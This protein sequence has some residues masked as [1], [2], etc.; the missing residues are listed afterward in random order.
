GQE[1]AQEEVM[2][3]LPPDRRLI[4]P[5]PVRLA[6]GLER[7]DRSGDA[8]GPEREAVDPADR[9]D[10]LGATLVEPDDRRAEGPAGL[11]GDDD[12][13]T[14]RRER[15]AGDLVGPGEATGPDAIAG[16]PDR[17]PVDL[18][19]LLCPARLGRYVGLDRHADVSDHD[20]TRIEHER[21]DAL[22]P[23]VDGQDPLSR[24]DAST[25]RRAPG[26]RRSSGSNRRATSSSTAIPSGPF[27]R[28]RYGA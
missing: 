16:Q 18:G 22:G 11:V 17:L 20:A 28:A 13:P 12:G 24:H 25:P 10:A 6:V 3:S 1:P 26:F 4:R 5:D 8:D 14:L 7:G 19:V 21:P 27:S 23:D 2:A 9:W 15:D